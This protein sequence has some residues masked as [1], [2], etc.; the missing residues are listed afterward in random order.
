[1]SQGAGVLGTRAAGE[2][3]GAIF[4]TAAFTPLRFHDLPD[5]F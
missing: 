5:G 3:D 2:R 1:M 4:L